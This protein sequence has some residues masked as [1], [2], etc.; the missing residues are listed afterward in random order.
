MDGKTLANICDKECRKR[1]IPKGKFYA[2]IGVTAPSFWG[3]KNGSKPQQKY[4]NAV[5]AYFGID[6]SE[7]EV[8]PKLDYETA[9]LL[10][11]IRSRPEL[12]ILLRSAKDMPTSSVYA[13][14]SQLEREK[15]RST[16]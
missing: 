5:E 4:I 6:L 16:R 9:E 12:G 2:D 8:D 1:G 11:S 15:E 3:W 14:L 13:L 7:Y 10:E